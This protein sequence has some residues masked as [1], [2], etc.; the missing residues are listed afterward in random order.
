LI[1]TLLALASG[2]IIKGKL[3]S[4]T[5]SSLSFKD[6]PEQNENPTNNTDDFSYIHILD[7]GF[8]YL[9]LRTEILK[10]T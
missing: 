8:G 4:D 10:R 6:D 7:T 9:S 5:Y 3:L 1:I 2:L